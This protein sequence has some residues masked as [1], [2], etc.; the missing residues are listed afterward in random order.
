MNYNLDSTKD[1]Y[2]ERARNALQIEEG[3]NGSERTR[4]AAP[5]RIASLGMPKMT[6]DRKPVLGAD[7]KPEIAALAPRP[8]RA[9]QCVRKTG[10]SADSRT[11]WVKP[12]KTICAYGRDHRHH[13]QHVGVMRPGSRHQHFAHRTRNRQHEN[14][15]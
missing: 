4:P 12:P 14:R 7:G 2:L 6:P 1:S 10:V 15:S 11:D 13:D 3:I 5:S 9:H 8:K